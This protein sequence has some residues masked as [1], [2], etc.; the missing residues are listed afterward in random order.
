[1]EKA[2]VGGAAGVTVD[3]CAKC[4]ALWLDKG[5]MERLLAMKAAKA[6]DLGPFGRDR[7]NG[8]IAA[9]Q[10]PRDGSIMAEVADKAQ[11]HV[12]IVLCPDC[13]GKLLDAG[14]LTD[15]SEFTVGERL[16]AALRLG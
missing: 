15:L 14:E 13:G 3:R 16:R 10:C 9:L 4:G 11:A 6:V 8:P 1:M 12:L 5:E 7:P 2:S